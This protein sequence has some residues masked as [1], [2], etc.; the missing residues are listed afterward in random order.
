MIAKALPGRSVA[1]IEPLTGGLRNSNHHVRI[2]GMADSFVLR[3][4]EHDRDLCPKEVD[5]HRLVRDAVPVAEFVHAEPDGVAGGPPFALLRHVEGITF[6]EL[7][8]CGDAT[9]TAQAARSIGEVCARIGSFT[10]AHGGWLAKGPT[11]TSPL[12]EGED[13]CPRFIDQ[14]LE[15]AKLDPDLREATHAYAWRMAPAYAS[16]EDDACLVH[17]DFGSPNI[18]VNEID[19]R[20]RVA[21]ILDWELAVAGSPLIDVGHFLRYDHANVEPHF[22]NAFAGG[23]GHLPENWR[24]LARALDLTALCELLSRPRAL[25]PELRSEIV[26]LVRAT[27]QRST[28]S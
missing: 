15:N 28:V 7:R 26:D 3:I 9:A 22:S 18:L 19:G 14:C 27:A 10:F 13:A 1:G 12:L 20:W 6:R 16:V 24:E 2:D 8:R 17:C 5:I 11:P 4:Y 21:A 25:P 23:G